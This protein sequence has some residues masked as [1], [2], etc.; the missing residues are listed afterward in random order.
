[1][2]FVY[3]KCVQTGLMGFLVGGGFSLFQGVDNYRKIGKLPDKSRS[4][5]ESASTMQSNLSGQMREKTSNMSSNR[6]PSPWRIIFNSAFYDGL[7]TAKVV[8]AGMIV[9]THLAFIRHGRYSEQLVNVQKDSLATGSG[10]AA[11][12]FVFYDHMPLSKRITGALIWG[13]SSGALCTYINSF[14]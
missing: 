8:T 4:N 14:N 13:L 3:A 6:V 9:A 2:E 1:M 7:H 12:I 10:V 5:L 11:A